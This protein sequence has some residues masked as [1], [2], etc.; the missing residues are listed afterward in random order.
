MRHLSDVICDL[1]VLEIVLHCNLCRPHR[2][3]PCV[4]SDQRYHQA[5]L[6][7]LRGDT[8]PGRI[9][10]RHT[11]P[12]ILDYVSSTRFHAPG[13]ASRCSHNGGCFPH[14]SSIA[15]ERF[16]PAGSEGTKLPSVS[17]RI[18]NAGT[19]LRWWGSSRDDARVSDDARAGNKEAGAKAEANPTTEATQSTRVNM[20]HRIREADLTI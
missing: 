18:G 12:A 19:G 9:P 20:A 11:T 10:R 7:S 16:R 14:L 3:C 17:P 5:T 1:R 2:R 6:T 13:L 8:R 4:V 15:S